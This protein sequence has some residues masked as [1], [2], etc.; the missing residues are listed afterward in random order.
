MDNLWALAHHSE[1]P[2]GMKIIIN[3]NIVPRLMCL[4]NFPEAT[5]KIPAL[6]C[7]GN[8]CTGSSIQLDKVVQCGGSINQF[9]EL[10]F[11]PKKSIR[12]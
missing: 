7:I 4:L 6:R 3:Y 1:N 11:H 5:I 8:I 10:L 9:Y 12:K 2:K